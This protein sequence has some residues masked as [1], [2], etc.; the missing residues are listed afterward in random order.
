MSGN[1]FFFFW[2]QKDK[3]IY[4]FFQKI[5][6]LSFCKYSFHFQI[7]MMST[8]IMKKIYFLYQNL[9]SE[10]RDILHQQWN[11]EMIKSCVKSTS[12]IQYFRLFAIL[13]DSKYFFFCFVYWS[14]QCVLCTYKACIDFKFYNR[15]H[16]ISKAFTTICTY[17]T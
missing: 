8:I 10:I 16:K 2:H 3:E 6:V 5:Y 14:V 12:I 7:D 1:Y 11:Q 4:F 15:I 17:C 9:I 13:Q